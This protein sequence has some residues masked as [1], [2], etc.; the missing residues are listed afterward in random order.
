MFAV[1]LRRNVEKNIALGKADQL[2]V[3]NTVKNGALHIDLE[4]RDTSSMAMAHQL[5]V[6]I[7]QHHF[8]PL[9]DYKIFRLLAEHG[10]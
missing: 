6:A 8:N 5:Q 2:S 1:G 10:S 3:S 7:L 9:P 4:F